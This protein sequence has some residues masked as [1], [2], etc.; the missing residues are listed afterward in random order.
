VDKFKSE[1]DFVAAAFKYVESLYIDSYRVLRNLNSPC[2]SLPDIYTS[3]V[4]SNEIIKKMHYMLNNSN[5][6][7]LNPNLFGVITYTQEQ[8][9][10]Q[11]LS[12]KE[13]EEIRYKEMVSR[14][15]SDISSQEEKY[16]QGTL[17]V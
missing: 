11:L 6:N 4:K 1:Y 14:F 9:D 12:V 3:M 10:K 8:L 15:T 17:L 2:D 13:G 16:V 7:G 5:A